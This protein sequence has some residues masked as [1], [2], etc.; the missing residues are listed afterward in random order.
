MAKLT[1]G[2]FDNG[3]EPDSVRINK[4]LSES[5][6]CSRREADRLVESGKVLID[7]KPAAVGSSG[8]EGYDRGKNGGA[9]PADGTDR[10]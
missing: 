4:Y 1:K 8:A 9:G 5:G 7:G 10:I 6:M 3:K 2:F